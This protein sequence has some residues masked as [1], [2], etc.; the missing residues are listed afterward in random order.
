MNSDTIELQMERE[1][2]FARATVSCALPNGKIAMASIKNVTQSGLQL[3]GRTAYDKGQQ[4]TVSISTKGVHEDPDENIFLTLN[5][6]C[7]VLWTRQ[8]S[9]D[10]VHFGVRYMPLDRR[11][12]EVLMR[13]FFRNFRLK[14]WEWPDKRDSP[15]ISR[16][17]VCHYRDLDGQMQLCMLRDLSVTGIGLVM[18]QELPVDTETMF[19]FAV[20]EDVI[21][22]RGGRVV[23]CKKMEKGFDVGVIFN[24]QTDVERDEI[25]K[26][27]ARAARFL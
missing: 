23:R 6:T 15:R 10:E 9:N 12:T 14:L 25:M 16:K 27:I 24:E 1:A 2:R 21:C 22:E 5:V 4:M 20:A 11:Q 19:R 26:A 7:E 13:F 3:V 17:L 18:V 8:Q